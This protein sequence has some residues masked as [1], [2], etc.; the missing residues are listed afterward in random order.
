MT[1]L[2]CQAGCFFSGSNVYYPVAS[3]AHDETK[4]IPIN[5]TQILTFQGD[6]V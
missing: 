3:H 4:M 2:N 5:T 6:N 1:R